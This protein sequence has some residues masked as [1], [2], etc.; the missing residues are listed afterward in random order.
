[1]KAI[2]KSPLHRIHKIKTT[3]VVR[4]TYADEDLEKLR[5][6]CHEIRNLAIIDLLNSTG[7]R[8]G[9]LVNFAS[10]RNADDK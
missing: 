4:E 5:D 2:Y 10:G 7:M 3:S 1:M 6:D 8:V 9:E